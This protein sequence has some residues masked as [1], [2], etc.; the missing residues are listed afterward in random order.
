MIAANLIGLDKTK[1]KEL[2]E[3]LNLLLANLQVFYTNAK[4]FHWQIKSEHF[5]ELHEKFEEMAANTLL[6]IDEVAERILTL[7]FNPLHSFSDYLKIANICESETIENGKIA[8]SEILQGLGILL[9]L[10]RKL[11][12]LSTESKDEGTTALLNDYVMEQE[13]LVWM[14]HSYLGESR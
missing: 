5:F 8:V 14:Y 12:I 3:Q 2:A 4:G 7:G 6:K 11:V 9:S 13:K 10:E 1:A